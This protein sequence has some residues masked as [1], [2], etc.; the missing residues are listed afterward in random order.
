MEMTVEEFDYYLDIL[1]QRLQER[2]LTYNILVFGGYAII[3]YYS[4]NHRQYTR[5][6]DFSYL[7]YVE[8]EDETELYK[9]AQDMAEEYGLDYSW[10]NSDD[11]LIAEAP[12][13]QTAMFMEQR[14]GL[15]IYVPSATALLAMKVASSRAWIQAKDGEDIMELL[16]ITKYSR[17]KEDLIELANRF[18]PNKMYYE[19]NDRTSAQLDFILE[20]IQNL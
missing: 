9:I 18:M 7:E 13:K 15:R 2:S 20:K 10:I 17:N 3:K 16:N 14:G 6:T 8:N 1:G 4:N 19:F 12:V 11:G 5:D